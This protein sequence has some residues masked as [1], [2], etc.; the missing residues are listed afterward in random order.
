MAKTMHMLS[1][2][3]A[4]RAGRD[5]DDLAVRVFA[6]ALFGV[7]MSL[8]FRSIEQPETNFYAEFAEALALL[9]DG[10]PL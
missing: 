5:A 2:M 4:K 1:E 8:W 6:G 7:A 9:E 3:V 10:M